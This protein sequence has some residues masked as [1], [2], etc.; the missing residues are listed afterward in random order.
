MPKFQFV[1]N[2]SGTA[3]KKISWPLRAQAHVIRAHKKN[4]NISGVKA[5]EIGVAAF[6]AEGGVQ[7]PLPLPKSYTNKNAG[8]VLY[9]MEKRFLTRVNEGDAATIAVAEE[10]GIIEAKS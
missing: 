1:G 5:F 9:G 3:T 6:N 7:I 2:G 10:F 8:S 4:D